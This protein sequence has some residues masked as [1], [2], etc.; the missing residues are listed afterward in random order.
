MRGVAT[1]LVIAAVFPAAA[2]G[3]GSPRVAALQVALREK[4][5]YGGTVDGVRGPATTA[6]V[7]RFQRRAHLAVDG[8]VGPHTRRALGHLGRPPLGSRMLHTG[9]TG[10]DVAALQFELA[11]HGF[12]NGS[13]DGVFGPRLEA[14]VVRFQR[15]RG[16]AVD[17]VAGPRTLGAL[18]RPVPREPLALAWPVAPRISS[19]FGPRGDG[20]HPGIDL[21]ASLGTPVRAAR[22]GRVAYAG[23]DDGYGQVV[24]LHHGR[25]V[26]SWYAHLSRILARPGEHVGV[27]TVI[28]RVGQTGEATGP[29][30][31]FEVRVR[32]AAVDP[33]PALR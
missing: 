25:G 33:R 28:G 19:P 22:S 26:A 21:A 10:W 4:G 24:V 7:R 9:Y 8:V 1:V 17:G 2:W 27:G 32:G 11:W 31:H 14:A 18:G 23:W 5:S 6:A 13:F 16:L 12:P 20:F 29:H 30:L 3:M 15:F